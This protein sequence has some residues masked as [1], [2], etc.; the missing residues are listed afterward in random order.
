MTKT[1][2]GGC[3]CKAVRFEIPGEP[4]FQNHCQCLQCQAMSGTGHSSFMTFMRDG[5]RHSGEAAQWKLA[6]ENGAVKIRSFCPTCGS[7]LFITYPAN[8]AVITVHATS[9]DDPGLFLPQAV[10]YASRAREWDRLD[11]AL[12]TFEKMPAE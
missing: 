11:P 8:T 10:T 9:L 12:A 2:T 5:V 6:G 1:Y 3:A 4:V 7:P